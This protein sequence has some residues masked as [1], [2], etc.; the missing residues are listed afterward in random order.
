MGSSRLRKAEAT[1]N[2]V[3]SW[4]KLGDW[5]FRWRNLWSMKIYKSTSINYSDARNIYLTKQSTII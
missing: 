1:S 3:G 2:F 5:F 4:E